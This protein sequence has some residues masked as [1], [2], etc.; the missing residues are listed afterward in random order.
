MSTR[1]RF[2]RWCYRFRRQRGPLVRTWTADFRH[3]ETFPVAMESWRDW[4]GRQLDRIPRP[5]D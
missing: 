3:V 2:R 1:D 4:Y 5:L